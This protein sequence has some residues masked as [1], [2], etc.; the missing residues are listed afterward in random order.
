MKKK[1]QTDIINTVV[2]L[3]ALTVFIVAA[4]K[5]ISIL[6][7]YYSADKEYEDIQ[8]YV[9][10]QTTEVSGVMA[11]EGTEA[12]TQKEI[13]VDFA[14]LQEQN[15]DCIG[16]IYFEDPDISY[17]IMQGADNNEYLRT[18]FLREARTAG[19]I[20]IDAD[21]SKDFSDDNTLVYGH[22]MKDGTM[23]GQLKNYEKEEFYRK[24]PQFLIETPQGLSYYTIYACCVSDVGVEESVFSISFSDAEQYADYQKQA[25]ERSLYDTGV[26]V[27]PEQK[28]VTLVTCNQAGENYRLL[29]HAVQTEFIPVE[30]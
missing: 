29:L 14:A 1:K 4:V 22:N 30:K 28:T 11:T 26:E 10:V 7:D 12:V 8:S 13:A 18:T 27:T 15:E 9:Y 17:P 2:F 5:L 23:F 19:S 25:K 3:T 6:F 21:N 20:F 16:W 24:N